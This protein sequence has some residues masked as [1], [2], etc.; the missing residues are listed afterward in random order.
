MKKI[1]AFQ[2]LPVI[3]GYYLILGGGKIGTYFLQYARKNDFPFVLVIDRNENAPA[4]EKAQVLNTVNE[5]IN[6]LREKAE[7]SLKEETPT[8]LL[9]AGGRVKKKIRDRKLRNQKPISTGWICTAFLFSS[10][11][12]SL[13][14]SSC[15]PLPCGCVYACRSPEISN[16][17]GRDRGKV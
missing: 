8:Q 12:V 3:K 13:N 14:I 9:Q 11:P 7:T 15:R 5:L 1:E 16:A 6:I 10:A 17:G 4:S 2:S